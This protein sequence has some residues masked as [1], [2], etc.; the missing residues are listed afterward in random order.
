M[1]FHCLLNIHRPLGPSL[2]GKEA[3][4]I[5]LIWLLLYLEKNKISF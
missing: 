5:K 1:L 2:G 3:K 4:E